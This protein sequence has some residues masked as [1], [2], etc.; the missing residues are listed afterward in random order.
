MALRTVDVVCSKMKLKIFMF[1]IALPGAV[2]PILSSGRLF[3]GVD[4][5]SVPDYADTLF[6][7]IVLV[8]ATH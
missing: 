4:P 5:Q 3:A 7:V 1:R 8:V 2:P 6:V